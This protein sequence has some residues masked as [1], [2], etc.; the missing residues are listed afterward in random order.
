MP[1]VDW[2]IEQR[3]LDNRA[4]KMP[5]GDWTIERRRLDNRA[6]ETGQ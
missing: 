3:R 6:K 5:G 4:E 2:T 1:G